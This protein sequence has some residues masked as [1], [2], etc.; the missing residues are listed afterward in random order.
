M[1]RALVLARRA[2]ALGEVPVGAVVTHGGEIIG[3]GFNRVI[4]LSDPGAHAEML[5]LRAAG[6]QRG[7]YRLPGC[8]LYVTLEPCCMCAGALVHARV[9]RVVYAAADPKT[10]AD[11]GCFTLLRAPQHNHRIEVSSGLLAEEAGELLVD[12]FRRRRRAAPAGGA[13]P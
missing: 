4:A 11:G 12:F 8:T 5:A 1:R 3:E 7:N 9:E 10:G 6:R 2:E 13:P